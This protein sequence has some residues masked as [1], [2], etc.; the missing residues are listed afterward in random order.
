MP[1]S[2]NEVRNITDQSSPVPLATTDAGLSALPNGFNSGVAR[3]PGPQVPMSPNPSPGAAPN[4]DAAQ[5]GFSERFGN[6][7]TG[8]LSDPRGAA[9]LNQPGGFAKMVLAASSK[10][11]AAGSFAQKLSSALGNIGS[12]AS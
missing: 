5:P 9:A 1:V 11:M 7:L 4:I 3:V 12:D 10:S 2:Q 8:V 6:E